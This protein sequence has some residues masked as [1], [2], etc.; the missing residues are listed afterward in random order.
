MAKRFL[1]ALLIAVTALAMSFVFIACDGQT[2]DVKYAVTYV[3]GDGAQGTAPTEKDKAVGEKFK[4]KSADGITNGD[5][6]FVGWNDGSITYQP[7]D[8]YTMPAKA[9]TF[10]AQ[11]K[12]K[13][14]E[15]AVK[16][17]VTYNLN[18]GTGTAPTEVDRAKGEKFPVKSADGITNGDKSFDGWHD[19]NKKYMPGEEY[20]MPE[21]NVVFTAQWKDAP[22]GND[23]DEP[24]LIYSAL[25]LDEEAII[26]LYDDGTGVLDY[27]DS[28]L[29]GHSVDLTY[30]LN[31]TAIAITV[32][33][34]TANGTYDGTLLTVQF[35]YD[36]KLFRFGEKQTPQGKPE[37]SF[38]ANG[39]SGVAP[40]IADEDITYNQTAGMYSFRLPENTYT[41]PANKKFKA[42]G[43]NNVN[44]TYNPG[45]SYMANPGEK[46][47]LIAV[48]E[49]DAPPQITGVTFTGN[50]TV[51]QKGPMGGETI[52][53]ITIDNTDLQNI[54]VYY[55]LQGD[56]TSTEAKKEDSV[57]DSWKDT[58][59]YG[60]DALYYGTYKLGSIAFSLLVKA[61]WTELC[62]C[63]TSQDEPIDG[64][65]FTVGGDVTPPT[66]QEYSVTYVK[67]EG[68]AGEEPEVEWVESGEQ[69]T[70]AP[71]T[72]F[73]KAGWT[74]HNWQVT[75]YDAL[76]AP[77]T[78]ITVTQNI[79]IT[80]VFKKVYTGIGETYT[81]LDNGQA[82]YEG[83]TYSYTRT[84]DIIVVDFV[85]YTVT[86]KVNDA[87]GTFVMAD[88]MQAITFTAK[89]NATLTFDGFGAATLGT[90]NG[91]YTLAQNEG[92]T[93]TLVIGE[94]TY[95]DIAL[96]GTY[97]NYTIDVKITID[98]TDYIFGNP[99]TE[100][101]GPEEPD[102]PAADDK[103]TDFVGGTSSADSIK[104]GYASADDAK[105]AGQGITATNTTGTE[106]TFYYAS[107]YRNSSGKLIIYIY[108]S[109]TGLSNPKDSTGQDII[110]TDE[111]PN[112]TVYIT[113]GSWANQFI[114]TFSKNSEGKRVMTIKYGDITVSWVEMTA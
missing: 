74:F 105:A 87:A 91:T 28:G 88:G 85:I 51:P 104:Y 26:Y 47:T 56:E 54:K 113:S 27:Q 15:D 84:G 70:L 101:P 11:W 48:W 72:T 18:G 103:L 83:D 67:P 49:D 100:E 96:K 73:T 55:K 82:I 45:Q 90:H 30:T 31:G 108:Y 64:A 110:I 44:N 12:D 112:Q 13:G 24:E 4:L 8:V 57:Q 17:H 6:V 71:G 63:E 20:T 59:K 97:P 98:G 60:S 81:I 34:T 106:R 80:P 5:K 102:P 25:D 21:N 14:D 92:Y 68:V 16:Y 50:Y 38:S 9:V 33:E 35:T 23:D 95:S 1:T 40:T 111:T 65:E 32:G 69:V 89:N 22:G 19:G 107:V 99:Q 10:T 42:W 58:T 114:I 36:G 43:V 78:K 77:N 61:D 2:P 66:P 94:E 7:G 52:V 75:G 86:I 93:L 41:P 39:G 109:S 37:I 29:D 62:L 53:E 76:R 46:I 3:I 79:T